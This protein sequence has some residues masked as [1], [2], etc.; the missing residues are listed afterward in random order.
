[1]NERK[2]LNEI[3]RILM[4]RDDLSEQDARDQYQSFLDDCETCDN[5]FDIEEMLESDLGLEPD[6]MMQVLQDLAAQVG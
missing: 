3:E 1:M 6:Y 5:P 4:K 2:P